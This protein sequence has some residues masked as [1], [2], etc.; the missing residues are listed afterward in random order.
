MCES[1]L[2]VDIDSDRHDDTGSVFVK[3]LR[4]VCSWLLS[5]TH[6]GE[7]L[8][9][10]ELSS[11]FH[12]LIPADV[13]QQLLSVVGT[14]FCGDDMKYSQQLTAYRYDGLLFLER[15]VFPGGVVPVDRPELRIAFDHGQAYPKQD[16]S[17]SLPAT[18]TDPGPALMLAGA[19]LL[20]YNNTII[21]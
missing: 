11:C 10:I 5:V 16:R 13:I 6:Q 19:V 2:S 18:M 3:W 14:A 1:D 4:I 9:R 15:I 20:Y 21:P 17:Q 12:G 7:D 8:V